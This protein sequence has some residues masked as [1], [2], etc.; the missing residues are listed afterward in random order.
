MRSMHAD[1]WGRY[2]ARLA[3]VIEGRDPGPDPAEEGLPA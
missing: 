3:A 2:L 1:G